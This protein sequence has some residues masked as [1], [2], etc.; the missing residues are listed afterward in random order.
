MALSGSQRLSAISLD[1]LIALNDEIAAI[2]R[3]GVPLDQ[4]LLGLANDVPG[5]LGQIAAELGERTSRGESLSQAIAAERGHFPRLYAAVVEAGIKTGRVTVVLEKLAVTARRMVELRNMAGSALL[6]PLIVFFLAY[7]LWIGFV[8]W[9]APVAAPAY[10]SFDINAAAWI[11][12]AASAGPTIRYWGPAVPLIILAVFA[13]W[14][15]LSG[16]A[17]ILQSGHAGRWL[18]WIPGARRLLRLWQAAMFADVLSLLVEAEAPLDESITLAA[19]ASGSRLLG[20]EAQ[21]LAAR[22]RQG[23]SL[24]EC[25]AAAPDFPPLLCWL[26][27]TGERQ[28]AL[29]AALRH[30]ADTY[31]A[32][33][34]ERSEAAQLF[35]PMLLTVGVGGGTALAYGL[36]LFWPWTSL[37]KSISEL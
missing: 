18:S 29:A 15:L 21:R 23:A 35:L 10:E 4:G 17:L 1:D 13:S 7:L 11:E 32:R 2:V 19:E 24:D 30:A 28:G 25:L 16:R 36:L 33:A 14:W 5:R 22:L 31:R 20:D 26:V 3:A 34:R 6:Y 27:Q 9:V 12:K 37:L 8:L